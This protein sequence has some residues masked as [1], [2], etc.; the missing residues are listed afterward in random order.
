MTFQPNVGDAL[1]IDNVHYRI[2]EHPAARGIPYG[3]EGRAAVVYQVVSDADKRALKVFKPRFRLPSL[4]AVSERLAPFARLQGLRACTRTVLTARK[5]AE[6]LREQPDLTYAVLMPWIDGPTWT[7]VILDKAPLSAEQCLHV[8]QALGE[9][10]AAMEEEG[11]AHCDLSG[12]NVIVPALSGAYNGGRQAG[13]TVQLVDVEQLYGPGLERPEVLLAGSQGYAAYH[14]I[15]GDL[16]NSKADRFA[17]AMLL[18]EVLGWCDEGVREAAWGETYFDPAEIQHPDSANYRRLV[19]TLR[20]RWG[21]GVANLFEYAW[22]SDALDACPTFGEWLIAM[23]AQAPGATASSLARSLP[24]AAAISG[25]MA[26][27][28][29]KARLQEE[30]GDIAGALRS[31]QEARQAATAGSSLAGEL[32]IIAAGLQARLNRP[33]PAAQATTPAPSP[34]PAGNETDRLFGFAMTA[35]A[36]GEWAAA[37]ELLREVVR[38]RP[39]YALNGQRAVAVLADVDSRLEPDRRTAGTGAPFAEPRPG[40]PASG[41]DRAT[42]SARPTPAAAIPAA[43]P[44][45]KAKGDNRWVLVGGILMVLALLVVGSVLLLQNKPST[46]ASA[47]TGNGGGAA[48]LAAAGGT[49][50]ATVPVAGQAVITSTA[51]PAAVPQAAPTATTVPVAQAGG[52]VSFRDN[53]K[54]SDQVFVTLSPTPAIPPGK[55]LIGWLTNSASGAV[56]S[57]GRLLPDSNNAL[58]ATYNV[59]DNANLLGMYDG[60]KVTAEDLETEPKSP[61]NDVV[62]TGQLPPEAVVHI[63]H[64]LVTDPGLPNQM[65]VMDGLLSQLTLVRQHAEF[66]Q[67][68]Q[69]AGSLAGVKSHAEHLVNIIEGSKGPHYGDLNHDGKVQNPGD[70]VGLL[71]S[72]NQLGYIQHVRDHAAKAAAVPDATQE[73]MVHSVHVDITMENVR[74]WITTVRDR[75]LEVLA[76][77]DLKTTGPLSDE[78]L[79]LANRAIS[80]QPVGNEGQVEPV[81]GSGG[82]M[83]GYQHAQLMAGIPLHAPGAAGTKGSSGAATPMQ[84][85]QSTG[86]STGQATVAPAGTASAPSANSQK[87]GITASSFGAP[88]TVQAGTTV[89]WSN[90]DSVPHSVTADNGEFDSTLQPGQTFSYTFGKAGQYK[91]YCLFHGGPGGQGMA[92]TITVQP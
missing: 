30:Q 50:T 25:D 51:T 69:A 60:F 33:T 37:Q 36:R 24:G 41:S 11:V 79:A 65:S 49:G 62:L 45:A 53:I 3:Q 1:L 48:G 28:L 90:K 9:I 31:Y 80:G 86:Q 18:G 54:R 70:G 13:D 87:I 81:P 23:P 47:N 43:A 15:Q 57:V 67:Q 20:A 76:A 71:V 74:G 10:L 59:P 72:N 5:D 32:G 46:P 40:N 12:P 82:A 34:P 61:S 58:S 56:Q 83:T 85:G 84:T 92:S 42:A 89:V 39:D 63:G 38:R 73:I 27:L 16:W 66:M 14:A 78:I 52:L 77:G 7:E 91:Y 35:Y 75:A 8:A 68:S 6:L 29:E 26:T 55:G 44:A 17:G 64:V 21:S 2:A 19:D 4:V 88:L 22:R